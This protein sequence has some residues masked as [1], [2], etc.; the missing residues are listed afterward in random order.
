[1]IALGKLSKNCR[2]R[3]RTKAKFLTE[4][5]HREGKSCSS[6]CHVTDCFLKC[7]EVQAQAKSA[8]HHIKENRDFCPN[9]VL[10]A[11]VKLYQHSQLHHI[12]HA[13]GSRRDES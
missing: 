8:K 13:L 5:V 7:R 4:K 9:M 10:M 1:M 6:R 2:R 3:R 12:E 11:H